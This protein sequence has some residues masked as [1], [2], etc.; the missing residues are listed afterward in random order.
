MKEDSDLFRCA[1]QRRVAIVG[2]T[3]LLM[4]L[5]VVSTIWRYQRQGENTSDI[6]K[7][8]GAIYDKLRGVVDELNI[9]GG[10]L[11]GAKQAFDTAMARLATGQGNALSQL[12]HLEAMGVKVRKPIP[13][14]R[15]GDNEVVVIAMD[16]TE[17]FRSAGA[18][19][20]NFVTFYE[21]PAVCGPMLDILGNK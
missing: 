21:H 3:S 19:V 8:A 15:V 1:W 6:A 4:T 9:A 17:D 20:T 18:C 2:P 11:S 12:K 16:E 13:D 7:R 10:K 14:V 5:K